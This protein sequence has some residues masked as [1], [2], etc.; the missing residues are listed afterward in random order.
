MANVFYAL[1]KRRNPLKKD[2]PQLYYAAAQKSG[3]LTF[4]ELKASIAHATMATPADVSHIVES[5]LKVMSDGLKSGKSVFLDKFG[6]FRLSFSSKGA[7]SMK[8]FGTEMIRGIHIVFRP[9]KE[10]LIRKD[11]LTFEQKDTV[12]DHS[13]M[14]KPFPVSKRKELCQV[15]GIDMPGVFHRRDHSTGPHYRTKFGVCS[16]VDYRM[17]MARY[18][19]RPG[20]PGQV[21]TSL[22]KFGKQEKSHCGGRS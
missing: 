6:K 18:P 19:E 1:V 15:Y 9:S 14:G 22:P 5:L 8:E 13:G 11:E 20:A 16:S 21:S 2:A 17:R 3:D 4:D 10:L 7:K 12:A